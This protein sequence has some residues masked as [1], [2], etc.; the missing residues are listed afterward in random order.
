[1]KRTKKPW[2]IIMLALAMCFLLYFAGVLSGLPILPF[3]GIKATW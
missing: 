1:M 2:S 3:L